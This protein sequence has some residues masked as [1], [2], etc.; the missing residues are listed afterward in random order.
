[1]TDTKNHRKARTRSTEGEQ[2]EADGGTELDRADR[3][4]ERKLAERAGLI[5]ARN[6]S[7]PPEGVA[8]AQDTAREP[9]GPTSAQVWEIADLL[10][11]HGLTLPLDV[12]AIIA[13]A[14][15]TWQDD[16]GGKSAASQYRQCAHHLRQAVATLEGADDTT[17]EE[18][19]AS[20]D[21]AS[22]YVEAAATHA[23]E[24][25]LSAI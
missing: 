17:D 6:Q 8:H 19:A 11:G 2:E 22:A 3:A 24:A 10:V 21:L 25:S 7:Q 9:H 20:A 14:R 12:L 23:R 1:M 4:A 15:A 5:P 18:R 13:A 16:K